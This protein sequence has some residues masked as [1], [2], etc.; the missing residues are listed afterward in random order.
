MY[1]LEC[2]SVILLSNDIILTVANLF[3]SLFDMYVA[4]YFNF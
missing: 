3:P 4:R 1:A 2:A